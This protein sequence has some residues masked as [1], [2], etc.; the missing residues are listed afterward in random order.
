[1][2]ICAHLFIGILL[3][4]GVFHITGDRRA[5]P[6]CIAGSLLPDLLDK[7]LM[8]L[9][10]GVFGSTRT[11]GHSLLLVT[12]LVLVA[13]ILWYRNRTILGIAFAASVLLHQIPD[14]MWT[15]P[16]TWF[17]PLNGMFSVAAVSGN[18]LD[19]L[20]LELTNP[21]EWVFA[22]ASGILVITVFAGT[23]EYRLPCFSGRGPGILLYGT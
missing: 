23:K 18:F 8:L 12:V 1:M 11:I 21:S 6:V 16:V 3:G 7:P 10:P 13:T 19:F 5:F 2:Y 4:L 9:V 17:F 14:L 20:L 15:F 22:L